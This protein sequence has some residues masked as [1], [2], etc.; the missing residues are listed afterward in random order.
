[1]DPP[2]HTPPKVGCNEWSQGIENMSY[3]IILSFLPVDIESVLTASYRSYKNDGWAMP[4]V[5]TVPSMHVGPRT[6]RS[7]GLCQ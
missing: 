6:D 5:M 1:M 2:P 7:H 4:V 3:M